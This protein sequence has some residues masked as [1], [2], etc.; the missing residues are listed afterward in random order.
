[1][2]PS[3]STTG[4]LLFA[5]LTLLV[6][7]A[8]LSLVAVPYGALMMMMTKNSKEKVQLSSLRSVGS[9]VGAVTVTSVVLPLVAYFGRGNQQH[10]FTITAIV[11]ALLG[12]ALYVILFFNTKERF[13]EL[14]DRKPLPVSES[15]RQVAHN[16]IFLV[17]ASFS[18]IHLLRIGCIL[19]LTVY[20]ALLVLKAPWAI[21]FLFGVMSV[22]SITSASMATPFFQR[23]GFRKGNIYVL[24]FATACYC[25]LPFLEAHPVFFLAG[26]CVAL[27]GAQACTT[28]IF[29]MVANSADYHE[30]KFLSRADGLISSC[31][32]LSTK[33]G[34]A[35]GAA[36]IA[37][38]LAIAHYNAQAITPHSV[39]AIR[40][41]FYTV[42]MA[43]M[44]IQMIVVSF[45]KIDTQ[46][47]FIVRTAAER[48]KRELDS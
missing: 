36:V 16:E 19:S 41:M 8:L 23:F 32:S 24:L 35:L 25:V 6:L 29:A 17:T 28:A 5:Y 11:L 33:L 40:V 7:G 31:W 12:T 18:F 46:H 37:F 27:I 26:F 20:F 39:A 1:M 38:G 48:V 9:S 30:F 42:P 47:T 10:G 34:I 4:K 22:G 21:P 43:L 15:I 13:V 44:V 3:V 45:Y 14:M 2:S